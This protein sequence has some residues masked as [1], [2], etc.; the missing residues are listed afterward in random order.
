MSLVEPD[1]RSSSGSLAA[2]PIGSGDP[3]CE[4][5]ELI[6]R[7]ALPIFGKLSSLPVLDGVRGLAVLLVL[8]FH[9][10][11][12][13][14]D[15]S[16][17]APSADSLR[18]L[19]FVGWTGVDL[20]FVLSGFLIT[21][22]LLNA[23]PN[24]GY[25]RNFYARRVL[26]IFPLYYATLAFVLLLLPAL[27]DACGRY[28]AGMGGDQAYLW[29]YTY[30]I[31]T[32]CVPGQVKVLHFGHFWSLCIE[33]HF[34]LFWPILVWFLGV[35]GVRRGCFLLIAA[36]IA[37]PVG[38][39]LAGVHATAIFYFTPCRV[40]SLAMGAWVATYAVDATGRQQA[41]P[42]TWLRRAVVIGVVAVLVEGLV[43]A[44]D[45]GGMRGGAWSQSIGFTVI[46]VIWTCLLVAALCSRAEGLLPRSLCS[47]AMRSLGKYSYG[48][49]VLHPLVFLAMGGW[50]AAA[51]TAVVG[52]T[53]VASNLLGL[54]FMFG[55][56]TILSFAAAFC[57]YQLLERPFL[58]LKR[59][60]E[61]KPR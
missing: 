20:F 49:Y 9:F 51:A 29:T 32:L 19:S 42:S 3:P 41:L 31:A 34:Y 48:L 25:F 35:R 60:F 12:N 57:V 5:N 28:A 40:D 52:H 30:N 26:R 54:L 7:A 53:G 27:S 16:R 24:P 47:R 6:S 33:E 23:R 15:I 13:S 36:A 8:A 21:R 55:V 58:G 17:T 11:F 4:S 43:I 50:V 14:P 1:V 38:L 10:L 46:A 45:H 2:D 39:H 61:Y 44:L 37:C 22:I 56:L 18:M 59:F